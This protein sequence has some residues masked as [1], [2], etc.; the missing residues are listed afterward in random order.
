ME[1][2]YGRWKQWQSPGLRAAL[3]GHVVAVGS[4]L[5]LRRPACDP[6]PGECPGP[7]KEPGPGTRRRPPSH[8]FPAARPGPPLVPP[9]AGG[10]LQKGLAVAEVELHQGAAFLSCL[11]GVGLLLLEGS[12]SSRTSSEYRCM[13][14]ANYRHGSENLQRFPCSV[15]LR[16]FSSLSY[17]SKAHA[18]PQGTFLL[19]LLK[20]LTHFSVLGGFQL[21]L[22]TIPGGQ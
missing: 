3:V 10:R 7:Q 12:L 6:F 9:L 16:S 15:P 21:F 8:L 22:M 19:L 13:L 11:A 2:V 18:C 1:G 14:E 20:L 17:V 4:L 5:F